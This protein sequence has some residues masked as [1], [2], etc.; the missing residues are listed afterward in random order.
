MFCGRQ[1]LSDSV[2]TPRYLPKPTYIA[3]A[4]MYIMRTG[5]SVEGHCVVPKDAW[6]AK[7]L[8]SLTTLDEYGYRKNKYTCAERFI[9]VSIDAALEQT[10][11]ALL[12]RHIFEH[13]GSLGGV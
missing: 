9:K 7:N 5:I 4:L 10:A 8:P 2:S 6:L 11:P 12:A 1:F 3:I 13:D